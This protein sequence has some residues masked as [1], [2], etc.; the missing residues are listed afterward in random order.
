VPAP[1]PAAAATGAGAFDIIA[2]QLDI[3]FAAPPPQLY[4]KLD[5]LIVSRGYAYC[6]GNQVHTARLLGLSRHILR[7]LLKRCGL[8]V[9]AETA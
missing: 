6:S 3:L 5:E 7:T 9:V 1:L 2:K 4:D 8:I